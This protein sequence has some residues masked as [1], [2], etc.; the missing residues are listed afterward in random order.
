MMYVK[1]YGIKDMGFL[2]KHD[3]TPCFSMKVIT[4]FN[5]IKITATIETLYNG[6]FGRWLFVRYRVLSVMAI[7]RTFH[8]INK[9][10]VIQNNLLCFHFKPVL[11]C[12]NL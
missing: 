9:K 3:H 1:N 2:K 4:V 12:L 8:R 7:Q 11:L 10:S 5:K 6:R